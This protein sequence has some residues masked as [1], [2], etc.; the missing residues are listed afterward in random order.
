[1]R[2][3]RTHVGLCLLG[4]LA[5][6]AIRLPIV[7][8]SI[9]RIADQSVLL[10]SDSHE[11]PVSLRCPRLLSSMPGGGGGGVAGRRSR[12]VSHAG[13][14]SRCPIRHNAVGTN[15]QLE[16]RL[17]LEWAASE[18]VLYKWAEFRLKDAPSPIL[19]QGGG[20]G[21]SGVAWRESK[22]GGSGVQSYPA[23]WRGFFAG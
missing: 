2:I 23:F 14:A 19:A 8:A 4:L 18:R 11:L 5:A 22:A 3:H 13:I 6:P 16:V 20:P 1:M 17:L 21:G 12:A 7:A 15:G 10:Q 9:P